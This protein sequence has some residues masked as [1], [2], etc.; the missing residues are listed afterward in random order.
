M[1]H[2]QPV[3]LRQSPC[4]TLAARGCSLGTS[5][6]TEGEGVLSEALGR[7]ADASL[8]MDDNMALAAKTMLALDLE[9]L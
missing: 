5:E 9:S 8:Y 4:C 3:L 1:Y 7:R 6:R 2:C